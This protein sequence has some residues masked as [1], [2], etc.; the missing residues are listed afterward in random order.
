MRAASPRKR[1]E[2]RKH[3]IRHATLLENSTRLPMQAPWM[4]DGSGMHAVVARQYNGMK[5]ALRVPR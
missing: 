2:G 5:M 3:T 4:Q 1:G